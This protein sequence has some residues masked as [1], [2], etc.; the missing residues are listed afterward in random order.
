MTTYDTQPSTLIRNAAAIMTGG[1][2]TADDPSRVPGPD[3]RIVG[4]T[5]DAIG[6]LTPRLWTPPIA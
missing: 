6:A 2:G 5:I 4:D 3:I 1:R